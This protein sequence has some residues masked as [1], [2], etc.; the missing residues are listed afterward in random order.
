MA[1]LVHACKSKTATTSAKNASPI[2]GASDL[3]FQEKFFEAQRYKALG[4]Y[5]M[6]YKA[7]MEC[8]ALDN[9]NGTVNYELARIEQEKLNN[10]PTATSY[11]QMAV[12]ADKNNAWYHLL[13]AEL[14]REQGKYSAAAKEYK[15]VHRLNPDDPAA[16]Y[17]LAGV[18]LYDR[19]YEE[20]IKIYDEIESENGVS[21]ELSFQKHQL[22]LQV[23]NL[24]KAG[25]EL[26]KLA[27]AYPEEARY[28]GIVAQFFQQ[29]NQPE[30]A[31][32]ALEKMVKADPDNGQVHYQLSEYYATKG[33]EQKSFEE[34]KAAF[35]TKDITIDQKISV[36]LKYF[37]LT[38]MN[39]SY[40]TQ[41]YE[42]LA[43]TE[44]LHPQEAKS[45]SIYGDFLYRDRRDEEALVKYKRAVELDP[46]KS[47]I[48]EQLVNL[49]GGLQKFDLLE[50]DSK[51]AMELFPSLPDFYYFNGIANHQLKRYNESVESLN[52][53]KELVLDDKLFKAQFYSALGS[54]YH[55]LKDHVR[56]DEA[57]DEA[58]KI[59]SEN[60]L[61]LNNYAYYLSLR[62][63][64]L[65]KAAEMSKKANELN[66]NQATFEDTYAWVLYELK[67]YSE[68]KLWMEKCISHGG[69]G[70]EVF[71]HYGDILYRTG[72][73]AG[74]VDAWKKSQAEGNN[75]E[76]LK[77]KIAQQKLPD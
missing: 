11:A 48:W 12:E 16:L 50:K 20:A 17:E 28:W 61:V 26:E 3:P 10:L 14:W 35:N 29:N 6:A 65:E 53:G 73:K 69:S 40:T 58:L 5:Q 72:D 66:P 49:E 21:E 13:L 25:K 70:A 42:L 22:Y 32:A 18:L 37:S 4:N 31:S 77:Q 46:S 36:L 41:A 57:F 74:A 27:E 64:K 1:L 38:Q 68:A 34:L 15:E 76:A 33:E 24:D 30:K 2:V 47:I 39:P 55:E 59:D 19:K 9:A 60:V 54:A 7:F 45:Y 52:I 23:K 44:K 56:S 75:S 71:E 67:R 51:K 8:R 62:K 43:I 63:A